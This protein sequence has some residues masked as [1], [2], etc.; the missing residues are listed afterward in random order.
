MYGA[1][2][3]ASGLVS[4]EAALASIRTEMKPKLAELNVKIVERAFQ[5]INN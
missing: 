2:A 4:L 3:A 1:L 5:L